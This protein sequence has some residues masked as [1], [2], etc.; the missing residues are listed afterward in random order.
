MKDPA[1]DSSKPF[2]TRRTAWP[3]LSRSFLGEAQSSISPVSAAVVRDMLRRLRDANGARAA[4]LQTIDILELA[5]GPAEVGPACR[6]MHH[7]C[8]W[9][10]AAWPHGCMPVRCMC[11][12]TCAW[13]ACPRAHLTK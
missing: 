11:A 7:A 5:M 3:P 13:K 1:T 6:R 12:C 2:S 9:L 4:A 8:A 10:H